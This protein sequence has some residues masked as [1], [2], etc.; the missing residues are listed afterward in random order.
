MTTIYLSSTYEDLKDHRKAVFD[1]LRKAGYHVIAMEDYVATDRRPVDK[2]LADVERADIYVGLFAFRYGYV[3]PREHGNPDGLSITELEFRHAAKLHKPC[4]TF[5]VSE[6]TSWPPKFIDGLK[7]ERINQLREYLLTEKSASFFS[8]PYQLASLVQAAVTKHLEESRKAETPSGKEVTPPPAS[9]W[10][11]EKDGSPYP[12]LMHFTRKYARV[13]FGRE[14]EVNEIL[15]RIR[16][17]E[18]R[19]II[20]SGDSGTGK[21]SLVDAGALP[22]IEE[23]GL[24][25]VVNPFCVRMVPSG[26]AHP[27]DALMRVLHVQVEQASLNPYELGNKLRAHPDIFPDQIRTIIAK[28]M[29]NRSLIL[30]LDQMEEL[31]T[32]QAKE[33]A[34]PFLSAVYC[35]ANKAILHVIATI[36]SDFLHHCH[37]Y[38]EML[39]VINGRGHYG[40]GRLE[41]FIMRDMILEPAACAGLT[42]S[43]RLVTRLVQDTGSEPGNLPLLAFVLQ[44]LFDKRSGNAFSEAVY[45]SSGGVTGAIGEH[46][47]TVEEKLITKTSGGGALD[48][49]PRIFQSL[50]VVNEEG[51]PTRRRV[52][53]ADF[54]DDLRTVVDVLVTE[55]LLSTE[56]EGKSATVSVAHEKLFE[57][58]P[59]L[60]KWI[61]ENQNDLFILR[62]AEIEAGEW[63]KHRCDL[64][65]LWHP[66]RLRQLREILQRLSDRTVAP[67]VARYASPHDKLIKRLAEDSLSHQERLTISSYLAALGDPRRGVG[68]TADGL[69][70]IDWVDIPGGEV[71]FE[72]GKDIFRNRLARFFSWFQSRL[73]ESRPLSQTSRIEVKP[74]KLARYTVTNIQFEA[75]IEADDGYRNEKWWTGIERIERPYLPNWNEHNCPRENVSWYEAIAFCRWLS[76]RL[77]TTVRLPTEWEWQQAAT[78]GD[79]EREYPWPGAWDPA[80]CNSSESRL[81]RT[82]AVGV[83]PNGATAQGVMDMAGNLWEWCLNKY[84]KPQDPDAIKIYALRDARAIRGGSWNNGPEDL[85]SSIRDWNNAGKRLD[86]IGFRLAQDI[87]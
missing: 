59:A 12:G 49:L 72:W 78:G 51:R 6:E 9:T 85:R 17:P 31:F 67:I 2:C 34:E 66:D 69:P 48:L 41:Q 15:D 26:G 60:A 65:Y 28:G 8:S 84:G 68:L 43:D 81:N 11:I 14:A 29:D 3:P 70:D 32:A 55:R 7:G 75:F 54:P 13:F 64:R 76:A 80:K 57:A 42:V 61:G 45:D 39:T 74:F 30:F 79:A 44:R 62:Q 53:L 5:V 87:E 18:G 82:T 19:F 33:H 77:G 10:D 38:P 27:F 16:E 23:G 40:L 21:S 1:D 83:Y 25:G 71:A 52:P 56:G 73:Q 46:I 36:R 50:L 47:K 63:E 58:W 22:K 37:A 86:F 24:S 35:A 4:L 20:I